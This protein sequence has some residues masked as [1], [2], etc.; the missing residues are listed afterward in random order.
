MKN[1]CLSPLPLMALVAITSLLTLSALPGVA[2]TKAGV[3]ESFGVDSSLMTPLTSG[4]VR[5]VNPPELLGQRSEEETNIRIYEQA[6]PAVVAIDTDK[7][8]GSGTIISPDGMILTNAHVVSEGGTVKVTLA[9]GREFTADVIGF[10]ENGLDLAVVKIPNVRNLPTIPMA[11]ASSLRVGQRAYAIGN[12]FGRFQGTFTQGII[13]RIDQQRGLIQTDAAINPGNSGGP[14]LNSNGELIGVNTSIFTRGQSG[15]SIGIGFAIPVDKLPEFLTAVREGRA[16]RESQIMS[17]FLVDPEDAK[18]LELN[19][20]VEVTGTLGQ[21]SKILP[22]DNSFYDLYAFEGKAGQLITIDMV[23]DELDS[24]LILL[25]PN[26]SEV[27]QDDDSG[28]DKNAR[29]T[30]TLPVDGLY[31]I[32]ANSFEAGESGRYELQIKTAS[33]IPQIFLEERG[34]LEEGDL[35]L[36]SD[37][38]LHDEFTFEGKAD[39]IVILELKSDDFDTYLALFDENGDLVGEN[40]DINPNDSNSMLTITLPADGTYRI[41]VNS[42]DDTGRGQYHLTVRR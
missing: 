5:A 2:A 13:S 37:G 36:E 1:H 40:D 24:F 19:D 14:L 27:A 10:G 20:L 23:S 16:P 35:V 30:T 22:V 42:Y 12:P 4:Q 41:M 3:K 28:E 17:P 15:G 18:K 33:S 34:V 21:G 26:Q 31:T 6:S 29:I 25:G 7:S 38:S 39:E 8:N 32:L 11:N 9:D